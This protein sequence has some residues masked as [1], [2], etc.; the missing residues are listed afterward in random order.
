MPSI[1]YAAQLGDVTARTK[2]A[3]LEVVEAAAKAGHQLRQLWGFNPA[4]P[5]EHSSGRAVDFMVYDDRAAGDW[6]ADYLW[7][8]RDRL[9]LKWEIWRQRI[10]STSPGKPGT[11]ETM[12][13]RGNTTANHF[14]HVHVFL[15]DSYT[16]PAT[17]SSSS[18]S[19]S[20]GRVLHVANLRRARYA[21]PPKAGRPLGPYAGEV[22]ILEAM[23]AATG[24]LA[25]EY[26]DGH[27]GSQTVGDG[28]P[29]L[30]GARG[31]QIKHSG[32]PA[33]KADG[34]LGP[35]ELG[36]LKQL[37]GPRFADVRI[38]G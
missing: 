21:D 25:P 11:W 37:A 8:H 23:L 32:T 26:V 4:S 38:E 1:D 27:Y 19:S 18:S 35:R 6:I 3:A 12:E 31:F 2:A 28:S 33:A 10:R 7:E 5:P 9:G 15:D 36:M 13:D 30:G 16:A 17:S 24:W 22:K 14:D 29:G 20:G 34:W